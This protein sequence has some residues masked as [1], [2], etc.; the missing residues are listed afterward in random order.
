MNALPL[1]LAPETPTTKPRARRK[2]KPAPAPAVEP[3]P[4]ADHLRLYATTG[5]GV[6]V[7]LSALLNGFA[8]SQHSPI[9]WA[10]WGMGLVVPCIVLILAK[11]A[12]LLWRRGNRRQGYVTAGVGAGLLAL[13]VWHCSQSIALLT[14]S[15]V[16]LSLPMAVAIDAGLV[17]CEVAALVE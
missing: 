15:P 4:H 5:V 14:G 2:A 17:A 9:T 10:G 3:V 11:V 16:V 6:M 12:G 13:S 8:N 1:K 7:I